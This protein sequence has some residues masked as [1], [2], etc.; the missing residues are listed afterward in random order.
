MILYEDLKPATI[1]ALELFTVA[2]NEVKG[3]FLI[4]YQTSF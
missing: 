1:N 3:C 4:T 2:M